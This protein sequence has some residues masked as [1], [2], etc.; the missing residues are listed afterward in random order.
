MVKFSRRKLLNTMGLAGGGV[1]LGGLVR[2]WPSQVRNLR[3]APPL[4]AADFKALTDFALGHAKALGCAYTDVRITRHRAGFISRPAG[5]KPHG[6][7][8]VVPD[9]ESERLTFG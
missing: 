4:D 6:A 7:R 3:R 9:V 1:V 5:S 2:D 8:S